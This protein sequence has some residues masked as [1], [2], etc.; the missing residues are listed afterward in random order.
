MSW[1][2]SPRFMMPTQLE[3]SAIRRK[4]GVRE[5]GGGGRAD[6]RGEGGPGERGGGSGENGSGRGGWEDERKRKKKRNGGL[7]R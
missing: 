6:G 4:G 7:I 5:G 3:H 1:K 2:Y